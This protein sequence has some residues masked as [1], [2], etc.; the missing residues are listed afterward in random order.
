MVF[1]R[2]WFNVCTHQLLSVKLYTSFSHYKFQY[3]TVN[4]SSV[5]IKTDGFCKR[6]QWKFQIFVQTKVQICIESQIFFFFYW[7]LESIFSNYWFV[8]NPFGAR[9]I[10]KDAFIQIVNQ[11]IATG[12]ELEYTETVVSCNTL[13]N[14]KWSSRF[15]PLQIF[16]PQ[17]LFDYPKPYKLLRAFQ[18]VCSILCEVLSLFSSISCL[19]WCQTHR[20]CHF[21]NFSEQTG[22]RVEKEE[23]TQGN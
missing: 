10:K 11:F 12:I 4:I 9:A 8:H 18:L 1:F 13:L 23:S 22:P 14:I 2:S 21:Q 20:G 15:F 16:L 5:S 7:T 17:R 6:K 19:V 3:A